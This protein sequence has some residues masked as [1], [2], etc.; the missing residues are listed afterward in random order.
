MLDIECFTFLNRAL[1]SSLSPIVI[2]ATNRGFVKIRG[3]DITSPHG[4]PIDFLDR[5]MIIRTLNY[6]TDEMIQ[7]FA[8][9]AQIEGIIIDE[10]SLA[11]L[12]DLGENTSLRHAMQLLTPA[13]IVAKSHERTMIQQ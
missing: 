13:M 9:R 6:N 8:I 2:F 1:E 7:I 4:I 10:E 12:G 5:L 11:Y 3:T